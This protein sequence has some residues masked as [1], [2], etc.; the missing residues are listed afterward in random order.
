MERYQSSKEL[1][2]TYKQLRDEAPIDLRNCKSKAIVSNVLALLESDF[3]GANIFLCYYPFGSEINLL[4]LYEK[5]LAEGR[6]LYFP[7]SD[8]KNHRLY[9][10]KISDLKKDFHVGAYNIMEPN[11]TLKVFEYDIN[12][13]II[14][15]TPGLIFDRAF[16]RIGY[17]AGFYDR[18]LSDKPNIIKLA[19]CFE[20]QLL[21]SIPSQ[22]HDIKM[23]IIITE[24]EVL[25]GDKL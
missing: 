19:P 14:C 3:K 12:Q 7:V 1:R 6:L 5:L 18:F 23:D 9:F 8:A 10:Y 16:N 20:S 24:N 4:P 25:K 11:D 21:A 17:G 2:L 22:A 13:N 15:I